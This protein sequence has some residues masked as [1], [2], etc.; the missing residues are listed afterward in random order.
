M[1]G[2]DELR[3]P[4]CLAYAKGNIARLSSMHWRGTQQL[5]GLG[6]ALLQTEE[7][8][9]FCLLRDDVST[10][11]LLSMVSNGPRLFSLSR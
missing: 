10:D 1:N 6:Y 4:A 5:T 9:L 11:R 2:A 3:S 8:E 7:A